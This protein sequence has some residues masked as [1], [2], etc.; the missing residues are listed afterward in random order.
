MS[1]S[2]PEA[3]AE[4]NHAGPSLIPREPGMSESGPEAAAER[5]HGGLSRIPREGAA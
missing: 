5:D 4:R 2:G 3:V 1:E